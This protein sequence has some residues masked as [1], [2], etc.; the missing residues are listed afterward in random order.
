[1]RMIDSTL[2]NAFSL[3]ETSEEFFDYVIAN[4]SSFKA[5]RLIII[6]LINLEASKEELISNLSIL[7]M[8]PFLKG[9]LMYVQSPS[10]MKRKLSDFI[11]VFHE[12]MVF[13]F[14]D[15]NVIIV[16]ATLI[17]LVL[18]KLPDLFMLCLSSKELDEGM[19][20]LFDRL[21][22]TEVHYFVGRRMLGSPVEGK[23]DQDVKRKIIYEGDD[24]RERI[25]D[26]GDIFGVIPETLVFHIP[27]SITTFQVSTHGIVKF[28]EGQLNELI[29]FITPFRT[30]FLASINEINNSS[31]KLLKDYGLDLSILRMKPL[32]LVSDSLF[33][34]TKYQEFLFNFNSWGY[35]YCNVREGKES[36]YLSALFVDDARNRFK[37][38]SNGV[39]SF[40][41]PKVGCD[42]GS[43]VRF[44]YHLRQIDP[45]LIIVQEEI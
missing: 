20:T 11:L 17:P 10:L 33:S 19:N 23:Y 37:F 21:P 38:S 12:K 30:P 15:E 43:I 6:P 32:K 27:S 28:F 26:I 4:T 40:I 31:V 22:E 16:Q 34:E 14:T 1:M 5:Q 42:I 7:E 35:Y 45:S 8:K 3:S 44:I 29:S 25:K 24:A 2:S 18:L 9:D 41:Y 36:N 13:L 39:T